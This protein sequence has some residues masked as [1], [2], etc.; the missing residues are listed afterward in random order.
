MPIR[1]SKQAINMFFKKIFRWWQFIL[2]WCLVSCLT[3]PNICRT[4]WVHFLRELNYCYHGSHQG[5][6]HRFPQEPHRSKPVLRARNLITFCFSAKRHES[7]VHVILVLG[8]GLGSD[9]KGT[10]ETHIYLNR[11]P[12]ERKKAHNVMSHAMFLQYYVGT[13]INNTSPKITLACNSRC[14]RC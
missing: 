12:Q 3:D 8:T 1:R 5:Q 2:I 11:S 4:A 7:W 9:H 14:K 13:C 10:T 6:M